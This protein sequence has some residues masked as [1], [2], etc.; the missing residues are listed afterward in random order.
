MNKIVF[1]S[2][3]FF[4]A[5]ASTIIV[6]YSQNKPDFTR[7]EQP[8]VDLTATLQSPITFPNSRLDASMSHNS[9]FI[10]GLFNPSNE[11]FLEYTYKQLPNTPVMQC[12]V[13][14]KYISLNTRRGKGITGASISETRYT[15]L[16]TDLADQGMLNPGQQ[17]I[18]TLFIFKDRDLAYEEKILNNSLLISRKQI[19]LNIV[20]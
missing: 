13:Q 6:I 4:V 20:P 15:L 14:N 18:C 1:Y 10:I 7:L 17:Y 9:S 5:L 3:I 11:P 19:V 8:N 12:L 2:I 16:L